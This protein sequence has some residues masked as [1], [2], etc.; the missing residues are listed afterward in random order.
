M[1]GAGARATDDVV[2]QLRAEGRP[3]F[4]CARIPAERLVRRGKKA[5]FKNR[6]PNLASAGG[7]D[8]L[9]LAEKKSGL[10]FHVAG[11]KLPAPLPSAGPLHVTVGLADPTA[12]AVTNRCGAVAATA[13]KA[14]K[15]A[16][17]FP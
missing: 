4:V 7:I 15:H 5:S 13:K 17:R 9:E 14:G 2:V 16:L 1:L 11:T 3:D 8:A 10:A 12:S 6:K